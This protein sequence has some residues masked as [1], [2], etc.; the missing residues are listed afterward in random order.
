MHWIL[1]GLAFA[2]FLSTSS[3]LECK[4][5]FSDRHCEHL[6]KRYDVL[7]K[8]YLEAERKQNLHPD[9]YD[10]LHK[11]LERV[12]GRIGH[13]LPTSNMEDSQGTNDMYST[14]DK[15]NADNYQASYGGDKGDKPKTD[16][17]EYSEM[18][19]NNENSYGDKSGE[20]YGDKYTNMPE[21]YLPK[22]KNEED[23]MYDSDKYAGDV[24]NE[25][26]N[27]DDYG[28]SD[29]KCDPSV[30]KTKCNELLKKYKVMKEMYDDDSLM[31]L[32]DPNA[33]TDLHREMLDAGIDLPEKGSKKMKCDPEVPKAK[34]DELKKKY[35]VMKE[36]HQDDNLRSMLHPNAQEELLLEMRAAGMEVDYKKSKKP[37][38]HQ[39]TECKPS[40]SQSKCDDLLNRYK[41]MEGLLSDEALIKMVNQDAYDELLREMQ[42]AGLKVPE[43]KPKDDHKSLPCDPDV[44]KEKC[45]ELLRQYKVMKSMYNDESLM[46]MLN[47]N[48]YSDLHREMEAAGIDV[49]KKSPKKYSR[50]QEQNPLAIRR[51]FADGIYYLD[52]HHF[53]IC[54]NGFGFVHKCPTGTANGDRRSYAGPLGFNTRIFCNMSLLARGNKLGVQS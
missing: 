24:E 35:K 32:L 34:C 39:M 37:S 18:Y 38:R 15:D 21:G 45:E 51:C 33:Y 44:P 9:A 42:D 4:N 13:E 11:E 30:P 50:P 5:A 46:K 2:F 19:G 54:S 12:A 40:V 47:P 36:L 29:M 10:N 48:S 26:D 23:D 52:D 43:K 20:E 14:S 41:I 17:K 49:G 28:M 22:E 1:V 53:V 7:K 6:H 27:G 31:T 16:S 8:V 3:A 25:V